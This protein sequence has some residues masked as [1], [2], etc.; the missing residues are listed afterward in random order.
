MEKDLNKGR[1]VDCLVEFTYNNACM[2][3]H[4]EI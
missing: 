2:S 4:E 3:F 1:S